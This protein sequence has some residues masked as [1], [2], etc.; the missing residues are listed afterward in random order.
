M[1]KIL[2]LL[3]LLR[4]TKAH[5]SQR[6]PTKANAG[7]RRPTQAN[8]GPQHPTQANEDKNGPKRGRRLVRFVGSSARQPAAPHPPHPSLAQTR[9]TK[10]HEGQRRPTKRKKGP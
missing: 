6:R 9:P 2:F 1:Y 8:E 4:P 3:L 5:S 7:Q 10:A